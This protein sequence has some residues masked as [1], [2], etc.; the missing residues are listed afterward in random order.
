MNRRLLL[1][2]QDILMGNNAVRP[3]H[4]IAPGSSASGW[5]H[6]QTAEKIPAKAQPQP[7]TQVPDRL[8]LQ[9]N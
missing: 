7:V 8:P 1:K 5:I 2:C 9:G 6:A 4:W 3:T